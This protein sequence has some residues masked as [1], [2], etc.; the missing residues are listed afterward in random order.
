MKSS[1]GIEVATAFGAPAFGTALVVTL[2]P[3]DFGDER[4]GGFTLIIA[5]KSK[6]TTKAVP[7]NRTPKA[8]PLR[9]TPTI[10]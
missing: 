6:L 2:D 7:S 3:K 5:E 1:Y 9:F 10:R 8:P 4:P